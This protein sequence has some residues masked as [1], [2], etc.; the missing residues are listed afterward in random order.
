MASA[1]SQA[2]R[3]GRGGGADGAAPAGRA[4]SA[5]AEGRLPLPP[6]TTIGGYSMAEVSGLA[7]WL[8]N[9][10]LLPCEGGTSYAECRV[11]AVQAHL[12]PGD[13]LVPAQATLVVPAVAL[14]FEEHVQVPLG[15]QGMLCDVAFWTTDVEVLALLVRSC[16][17][18]AEPVFFDRLHGVRQPDWLAVADQAPDPPDFYTGVVVRLVRGGAQWP[19]VQVRADGAVV[20]EDYATADEGTTGEAPPATMV[21]SW[22]AMVATVVAS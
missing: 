15:D 6:P 8:V 19:A 10:Y 11:V 18:A 2:L 20:S 4:R 12:G 17:A 13:A 22:T 9:D 1:G 14:E 21:A 3:R 5:P 16:P 7:A